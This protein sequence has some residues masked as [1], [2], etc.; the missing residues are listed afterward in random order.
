MDEMRALIDRRPVPSS[1]GLMSQN[2]HSRCIESY[3]TGTNNKS[4]SRQID[5]GHNMATVISRCSH[6]DKIR[7]H[8][9]RT[10]HS[11]DPI[12]Y[13]LSS[14]HFSTSLLS[15]PPWASYLTGWWTSH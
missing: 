8:L 4:E 3:N 9:H 11:P 12:R 13:T 2:S 1:G 15:V 5:S 14:T 10:L 6:C 7:A